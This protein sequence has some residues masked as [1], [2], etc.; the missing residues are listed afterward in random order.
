M[1]LE[2]EIKE[3]ADRILN[4]DKT[5]DVTDI[6]KLITNRMGK[7]GSIKISDIPVQRENNNENRR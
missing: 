1:T 5:V 7:D 3:M 2:E 4:G 6:V